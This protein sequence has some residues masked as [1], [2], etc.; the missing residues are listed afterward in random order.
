MSNYVPVDII[1]TEQAPS[2]NPIPDALIRIYSEDGT[3]Y[4]TGGTT[5]SSGKLSLLLP[6]GVWQARLSKQGVN[7]RN[8]TYLSVPDEATR[9]IF[10]ISAEVVRLAAATMPYTC[11]ASTYIRNGG[12]NP[13]T[14]VTLKITPVATAFQF[15]KVLVP[16]SSF[17][18]TSDNSGYIYADL[19]QGAVYRAELSTLE[20]ISRT[21]YTPFATAW[22]LSDLLFP[23]VSSVT[24][25]VDPQEPLTVDQSKRISLVVTCS[26]GQL[27]AFPA[28]DLEWHNSAPNVCGISFDRNDLV[29]YANAPGTTVVSAT[30]INK[31][32]AVYPNPPIVGLP[33]T[34]TV[35]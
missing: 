12:G 1:T 10:D 21:I 34:I 30:R 16:G 15:D 8:P 22:N 18:A 9:V 11:R 2:E 6:S 24:F 27:S 33:F 26:D 25:S 31:E 20:G 35:E 4:Y 7:F 17:T 23:Y 29:L 28:E 19:I 32:Y 3:V 13:L 14:N 5:D